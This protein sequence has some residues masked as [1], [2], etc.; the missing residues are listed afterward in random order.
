M[1]HTLSKLGKKLRGYVI[2]RSTIRELQKNLPRFK[3]FP[4]KKS[5][6]FVSKKSR[7][8]EKNSDRKK[9]VEIL[10]LKLLTFSKNRKIENLKMLIISTVKFRPKMFR[11]DFFRS[12]EIFSIRISSTFYPRFFLNR[13]RF[14]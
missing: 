11:S 8:I 4:D 10:L 1:L 13:A 3:K 14:F 7:K 12:S 6:K 2:S 9:S 5:K